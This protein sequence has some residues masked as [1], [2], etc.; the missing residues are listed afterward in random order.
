MIGARAAPRG[1]G[2]GESQGGIVE[3]RDR[4]VILGRML[5]AR[6]QALLALGPL[7]L[8]APAAPTDPFA[9]MLE[10]GRAALAAGRG[11]EAAAHLQNVLAARPDSSEVLEL[12]LE[13]AASNGDAR[14]LWARALRLSSADARGRSGLE[15]RAKSA[16]E[17]AAPELE[18]L[19][20]A[21]FA[22][23][24]ELSALAREEERA[25]RT[26]PAA[27]IVAHWAEG[28]ARRLAEPAPAL[29]SELAARGSPQVR[30]PAGAAEATV[31]AL[32][33]ALAAAQAGG[34]WEEV[35]R[36]ARLLV[37]LG[38]QARSKDLQDAAPAGASALEALGR[39]ALERAR[40]QLRAREGEPWT[41]ER[42]A[43]LGEREALEFSRLHADFGAPAVGRSPRGLY[44][45]ETTCGYETLVGALSTVEAHH[46]RLAR[47][48]GSDPFATRPGLVRIHPAAADLEAESTPFWWAGGFQSGDLTVLR[49]ALGDLD[50]L[51]RGLVHELTHRFDGALHPGLPAWLAEGRAVWTGASYRGIDDEDFVP[52]AASF[53]TI[54]AAFVLGYGGAEKLSEL[55]RGTLEDY[56]DNYVAGY[57]LYVFLASWEEEGGRPY[58]GALERYML[59][60]A[61]SRA[62]P[63]ALFEQHFADGRE[64]RPE[65]FERFAERFGEFVRGFYWD[66]RAPWLSRYAGDVGGAGAP[67]VGDE[68]TWVWTRARAEPFYGDA[69]A[70]RA[71][72][73]LAELGR[74]SEALLAFAF[75]LA[76][77]ECSPPRIRELAPLLTRAGESAAAWVLENRLVR[78]ERR[79]GDACA[80]PSPLLARLPRTRALLAELER[81]AASARE[82]GRA[83]FADV[84]AGERDELAAELGLALAAPAPS[85]PSE[86]T[87]ALH[88][89]HA[90]WRQLGLRGYVEGP[91]TGYEKRRAKGCW[92]ADANGDLHVGREQP[93]AGTGV[94][95]RTAH[96]RDACALTQE[97]IAP[98]RWRLRTRVQLTTSFASGAL[99]VGWTRRDRNLR[100]ALSAGDFLYAIGKRDAGEELEAVRWSVDGQWEREGALPG[101]RSGGEAR[102]AEPR[103]HFELELRVDGGAL[104]LLIEGERV[105]TWHMPDGRPIEGRVG[106]AT[107]FGAL[108]LVAPKVQRLDATAR[109]DCGEPLLRPR[110]DLADPPVVELED[111]VGLPLR[112]LAPDGRTKL[113]LWVPAPLLDEPGGAADAVRVLER[114]R[115]L[116]RRGA[117]A[118][119][120][121]Q[122]SIELVL[123][124]PAF[125]GAELQEQLRLE[126]EELRPGKVQIVAHAGAPTFVPSEEPIPWILRTWMLLVDPA[127][128]LRQAMRSHGDFDA[129]SAELSAWLGALRA[130]ELER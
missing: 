60:L 76:L 21:R 117:R 78:F 56:R 107:S 101:L 109:I 125:L 45:V 97:W 9:A 16:V 50:G 92:Y 22:A 17:S 93:R 66:S 128:V 98:G 8:P 28:L 86:A 79:A 89:V 69:H 33:R 105:A 43:E 114:A 81:A 67:R 61:R 110:L 47:W 53:G 90:P 106:L 15:R 108:R 57:A 129:L 10:R 62:E 77:E 119:D 80:R 20:G 120:A 91:L 85:Q 51:G 40:T 75:G 37:G 115:E 4:A 121:R 87:L 118:L 88:P 72:R 59:A 100:I 48:Y 116:A 25:A 1:F 18:A 126:L 112:G 5:R 55:V 102:F 34:R 46:A 104:E 30:A 130:F 42:L 124:L 14:A 83:T 58:A 71:G 82:A 99:V 3:A 24:A 39:E 38:N 127:G 7:L 111:L 113:V 49:F 84:L 26:R 36:I 63:L 41:L 2:P 11:A 19:V 35:A 103:A 27:A 95:D 94:L 54:E 96:Q 12:L 44:R 29:A 123:A 68:P 13:A 31:K 70:W 122:A 64:G 74:E 52:N 6:V 65:G 73:L 23:I 32:Q